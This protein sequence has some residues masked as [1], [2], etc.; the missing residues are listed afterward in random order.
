MTGAQKA[1]GNG[2]AGMGSLPGGVPASVGGSARSAAIA[3]VTNYRA[4]NPPMNFIDTPAQD[5]FAANVFSK[6]VMKARLPKPVFKSLMRTIEAGAKLDDSVADAVA[7]AMKDWAIEKGATHY[8]HV[9][10]PLTGLTWKV[11]ES[12]SMVSA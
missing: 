3:A 8:A 5:L 12:A 6:A 7:S 9:F 4:T 1:A 2:T 11:V 10:F